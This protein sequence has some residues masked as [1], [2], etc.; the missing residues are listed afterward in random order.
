MTR[1]YIKTLT[2]TK[3][4]GKTV[5]KDEER[6]MSLERGEKGKTARRKRYLVQG[7]HREMKRKSVEELGR[8]LK[9]FEEEIRKEKSL[10]GNYDGN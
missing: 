2:G 4:E 5:T 7:F 9:A 8:K 1:K 6:N 10:R 3:K